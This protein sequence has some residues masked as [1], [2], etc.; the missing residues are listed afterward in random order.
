EDLALRLANGFGAGMA[1]RQEVCGAV[2]GAILVLG[3]IYG[4]GVN[5][6]KDKHEYTYLKVKELIEK[7][8]AQHGNVNCKNLLDG[9]DLNTA[10]GQNH[11]KSKNLIEQCYGYVDSV[12]K[13]L[14][15][16]IA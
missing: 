12:V 7:F 1:R 16:I 13:I 15:D 5:D 4:R 6:G 8:E 11:F 10:A 2:S 9:C 14:E 3:L